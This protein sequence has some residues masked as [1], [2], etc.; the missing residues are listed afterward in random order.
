MCATLHVRDQD[1]L[2]FTRRGEGGCQIAS[3]YP[4]GGGA[5]KPSSEII[6]YGGGMSLLGLKLSASQTRGHSLHKNS[7]VPNCLIFLHRSG[8]RPE[9]I[10]YAPPAQGTFGA[11]DV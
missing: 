7:R 2:S 8:P 9:I 1:T 3:F 6:A 11:G 5:T 10:A 4:K